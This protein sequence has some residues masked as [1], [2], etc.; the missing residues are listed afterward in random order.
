MAYF[1]TVWEHAKEWMA[2][3][4]W[5]PPCAPVV[6]HWRVGKQSRR[7]QRLVVSVGL[8]EGD[9]HLGT[10]PQ[11]DGIWPREIATVRQ[12]IHANLGFQTCTPLFARRELRLSYR[13]PRAMMVSSP[14]AGRHDSPPSLCCARR[15]SEPGAYRRRVSAISEEAHRGVDSSKR[16]NLRN[17]KY[18]TGFDSYISLDCC[19]SRAL[20]RMQ[21][22]PSGVHRSKNHGLGKGMALCRGLQHGMPWCRR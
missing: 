7:R 20:A 14:S 1:P 13:S 11:L 16:A 4:T 3:G 19:E 6:L 18:R 5:P 17:A 21:E 8:A 22:K 15:P 10:M 2:T 12:P 9:S